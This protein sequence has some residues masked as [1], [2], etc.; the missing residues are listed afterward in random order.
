LG[1]GTVISELA[2]SSGSHNSKVKLVIIFHRVL[3]DLFQ[4]VSG[5]PSGRVSWFGPTD[6]SAKADFYRKEQEPRKSSPLQDTSNSV[7]EEPPSVYG[8]PDGGL[9]GGW[10]VT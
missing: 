4:I 1:S 5:E 8:F 10:G 9:L 2:K 6:E 3:V 7:W